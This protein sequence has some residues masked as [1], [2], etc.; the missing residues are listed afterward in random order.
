MIG[1]NLNYDISQL[2]NSLPN[3]CEDWARSSY[4]LLFNV[5]IQKKF[6]NLDAE[7]SIY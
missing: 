1:G 7:L 2:V 5:M 3:V 6:S 4:N